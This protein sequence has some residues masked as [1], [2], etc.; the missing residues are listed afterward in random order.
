MSHDMHVEIEGDALQQPPPSSADQQSM[1]S[2]GQ[3]EVVNGGQQVT[4]EAPL[5]DQNLVQGEGK[6][7]HG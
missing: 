2:L 5:T 3:T 7:G 6:R 4:L 1:L